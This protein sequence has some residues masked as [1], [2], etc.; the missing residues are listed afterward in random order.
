MTAFYLKPGF[1]FSVGGAA[2]AMAGL[3][4]GKVLSPVKPAVI[5]GLKESY[6]IKDWLAG[7]IESSKEDLEDLMAE[8]RH[9]YEEEIALNSQAIERE[10]RLL[11][12]VDEVIK[13]RSAPAKKTKK[14]TKSS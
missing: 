2:C 1:L 4:L 5:A 14:K 7:R 12:K 10:K 6:L 9:V 8:A 3:N 13:K 11:D